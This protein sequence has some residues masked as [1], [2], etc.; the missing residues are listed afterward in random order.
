M[1]RPLRK[2]EQNLLEIFLYEAI[3]IPEGM[4]KPPRSILPIPELQVYIAGFGTQDA[5]TAFVAE[6]NNVVAG[7]VWARIM[8]DYG[9]IDDKTPS[10]AISLLPEF[11][12]R[13]LGTALLSKI[14][15]FLGTK[16][17]PQVSLAVQKENRA[18]HLYQRAGFEIVRDNGEEYIMAKRLYERGPNHD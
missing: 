17:Y 7:A 2:T 14:L 4:P 12:G 15:T 5:D 11:R 6:E 16:G 3:F 8:H 10:L 18:F 1:I 9:H 13:G